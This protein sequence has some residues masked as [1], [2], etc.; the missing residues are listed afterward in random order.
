MAPTVQ[1]LPNG[2]WDD[3]IL[4]F[5]YGRLVT[6]YAV[7]AE[8]LV[9]LID[10]LVS[11]SAAATLLEPLVPFLEE[12]RALLVIN[13]HAHWDHC[14]GNCAFTPPAPLWSA[15]I[16]AHQAG[17]QQVLAASMGDEL[18]SR[19]AADPTT[20]SGTRLQPA[21][22][23]IQSATLVHG[24][25]LTF[26]LLPTPGHES[27]HLAIFVPEIGTLFAGDAA[28]KPLP[29]VSSP[30]ALP[31]AR[32]SLQ[33]LLALEATTVLYAHAPGER[34]DAVLR[35]NL[36]YWETIQ[37]KAQEL[38]ASRSLPAQ[39]DGAGLEKLFAFP[40]TSVPGVTD[41]APDQQAFYREGHQAALDAAL[42]LARASG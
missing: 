22:I 42:T 30:P 13:T 18:A 36:A 33:R 17:V 37:K 7:V 5:S 24:G 15:P 26:H 29:F 11:R 20:F 21:T 14:W 10:T 32:V 40:F 8:R 2:G 16:I 12:G 34:T 1:L 4:A 6:T 25:D 35:A 23:T 27:D 38:A 19:L 9:L 39:V 28:E 3:R 41:L 31:Q